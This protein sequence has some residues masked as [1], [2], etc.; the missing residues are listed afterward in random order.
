M[1]S[2]ELTESQR[3]K[4]ILVIYENIIQKHMNYNVTHIL[5]GINNKKP[6]VRCNVEDQR[7]KVASL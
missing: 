7:S 2:H 4:D 3:S 6:R 5:I 1:G